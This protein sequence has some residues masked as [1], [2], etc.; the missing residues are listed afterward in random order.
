[1]ERFFSYVLIDEP[2]YEYCNKRE[3]H[4]INFN[5]KNKRLIAETIYNIRAEE[6]WFCGWD[7]ILAV[8]NETF[9]S[10]KPDF[11]IFNDKEYYYVEYKSRNDYLRPKQE[12]WIFNSNEPVLVVQSISK[13][14]DFV[15]I[16]KKARDTAVDFKRKIGG[17]E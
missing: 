13:Y 2:F 5:G 16:V 1:M 8:I 14:N 6:D 12:E 17:Q 10:G 15:E 7:D 4:I 3:L 11:F 9:K